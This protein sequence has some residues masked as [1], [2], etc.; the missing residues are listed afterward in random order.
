MNGPIIS[1]DDL[2]PKADS[3]KVMWKFPVDGTP[4]LM[5]YDPFLASGKGLFCGKE[6]KYLACINYKDVG[7]MFVWLVYPED[8]GVS[9][10]NKSFPTVQ[11]DVYMS[12]DLT[13]N[14]WSYVKAGV[15]KPELYPVGEALA[16]GETHCIEG[17]PI[18]AEHMH[19]VCKTLQI[20][21]HETGSPFNDVMHE[22]KNA[23]SQ[24]C[25]PHLLMLGRGAPVAQLDEYQQDTLRSWFEHL[26]THA[27]THP[28]MERVHTQSSFSGQQGCT[29]VVKSFNCLLHFLHRL[30]ELFGRIHGAGRHMSQEEF[31]AF[32]GIGALMDKA[33]AHAARV[34]GTTPDAKATMDQTAATMAAVW[35][36]KF[37]T[38]EREFGVGATPDAARDAAHAAA[39]AANDLLASLSERA[40]AGARKAQAAR[41]RALGVAPKPY[42]APG[43]SHKAKVP[44]DAPAPLSAS[45]AA[46]ATVAKH[47]SVE[48]VKAHEQGLK[49]REERR[50]AE[51]EARRE[52]CRVGG[53]IARGD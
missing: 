7:H 18:P 13:V 29:L 42:T 40:E 22:V 49:E 8:H 45:A 3:A 5:P 23:V 11:G 19:D 27:F 50:V 34:G 12:A 53:N 31:E 9:V 39:V 38:F 28:D 6:S 25:M 2:P 20:F 15:Y 26:H 37:S 32:F 41:A 48:A 43:P 44:E 52:A 51:L 35:N 36:I 21:K 33:R 1:C 46:K 10:S 16:D 14:R 4:T 17:L 47:A 30:S 24:M